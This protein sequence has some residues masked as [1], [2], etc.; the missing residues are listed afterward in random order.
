MNND[1][2]HQPE[3]VHPQAE[4]FD[5]AR[6]VI[7]RTVT[8]SLPIHLSEAEA[9]ERGQEAAR[10]R[11]QARHL[12]NELAEH[13]KQIKA[14]I[15]ALEN[16]AQHLERQCETES[17]ITDVECDIIFD[18]EKGEAR[19]VR[20]DTNQVLR[21]LTRS[22]RKDEMQV[23][24]D[25]KPRVIGAPE[26]H[27]ES[28]SR[29]G[30]IA[31]GIIDPLSDA[32]KFSVDD[33]GVFMVSD[34]AAVGPEKEWTESDRSSDADWDDNQEPFVSDVW[35]LSHGTSQDDLVG[36]VNDI[37]IREGDKGATDRA[38]V[39][40]LLQHEDFGDDATAIAGRVREALEAL[41]RDGLAKGRKGPGK[42]WKAV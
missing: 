12:A 25:L 39:S 36:A 35:D 8:E 16:R 33:V 32:I 20:R 15:R 27:D 31:E 23:Q 2:T 24:L 4:P 1:K 38:L 29:A 6:M 41:K 7:A 14:D 26:S 18:Y 40:E 13:A 17:E 9:L 21:H 37:L 22:L 10:K 42:R 3:I 11:A 19:T 28:A 5:D 34:A 30:D